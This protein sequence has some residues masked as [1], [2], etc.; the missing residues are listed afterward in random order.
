MIGHHCQ[1]TR[2]GTGMRATIMLYHAWLLCPLKQTVSFSE[3]GSSSKV[4][5]RMVFALG[6]PPDASYDRDVVEKV[7]VTGYLCTMCD[8][9]CV[10]VGKNDDVGLI[11]EGRGRI[12]TPRTP[13]QYSGA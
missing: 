6:A 12:W 13:K 3:A 2:I 1:V 10:A 9:S 11:V 4:G 5:F 8:V 7:E